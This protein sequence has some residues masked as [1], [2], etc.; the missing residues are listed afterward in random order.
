MQHIR[1]PTQKPRCETQICIV[2]EACVQGQ[3]RLRVCALQDVYVVSEYRTTW[4]RW[5]IQVQHVV[6][7][8]LETA[9]TFWRFNYLITDI[10]VDSLIS[11]SQRILVLQEHIRAVLDNLEA[12]RTSK[13]R[14]EAEFTGSIHRITGNRR[15]SL[16][17]LIMAPFFFFV[18]HV[19]PACAGRMRFLCAFPHTCPQ[20]HN[21]KRPKMVCQQ[22]PESLS[23][24][25]ASCSYL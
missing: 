24:Q 13:E 4:P 2:M 12:W 23:E 20:E 11:G 19:G 3:L 14:K 18:G 25:R 16:P 22:A 15:D 17:S 8:D 6:Y 10:T 9:F 1:L 7:V 21:N 5:Y